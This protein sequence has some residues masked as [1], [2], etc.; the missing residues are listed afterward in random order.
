[1]LFRFLKPRSL[2]NSLTGVTVL[3]VL[4]S[5]SVAAQDFLD[6]KIPE[7]GINNATMEEALRKL[8]SWGIQVCLEQVPRENEEEEEVRISV[9]LQD[10]SVKEVL[11]ALVAADKRYTWERYQRSTSF[12]YTNLINVFPVGAKKDP[13]N[14]MSIKAKKVVMKFPTSPQN[15]ISKIEYFVP[16]IARKLHQGT[17]AGSIPG[18]PFGGKMNLHIDFEFEEMTVREILNE[19]ALRTAGEGWVYEFVKLPK[20]TRK[21]RVLSWGR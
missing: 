5:V 16:E 11:N 10:A 17:V 7:Y 21:W 3:W 4:L 14:L 6:L 9:R 20:P 18:G 13:N 12:E 1:M 8:N 15:L 19:I 2:G